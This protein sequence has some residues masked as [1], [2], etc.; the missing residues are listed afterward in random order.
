MNYEDNPDS[1]K[2]Y[3]KRFLVQNKDE[4]NAKKIIDFPAGNGITS[5]IIKENGGEPMAFDL[6]PEY[7]KVDGI[8][9]ERASLEQGLPVKD[10]YA[11]MLICQEGMEHF[12]DQLHAF[13]EFNRVLKKGGTL[14]ITTPNYSN[15]RSKLSYLLS[16]SER[17][18]SSMPPNEL[19]SIWMLKEEDE[20]RVYY[21]HLFLIGLQKLRL[22]AKIAGFKIKKVH[23]TKTKSTSVLLFPIFYPF[24]LLFSLLTYKNSLK[25][26]NSYSEETK[27][28]VYGEQFKLSIKPSVLTDSHLMIEFEKEFEADKVTQTLKSKHLSFDLT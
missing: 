21:G 11:D 4:I 13:K 28:D 6:F 1:I 14:L 3:V 12:S 27:K 17:F 22:F 10:N 9:C 8:V 24:I 25:G 7:F 2:F 26:K 16:E 5:K 15:L 18:G 23:K 19:D 20:S